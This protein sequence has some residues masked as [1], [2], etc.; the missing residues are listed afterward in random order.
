MPAV[1]VL[2]GY[3][4]PYDRITQCVQTADKVSFFTLCISVVYGRLRILSLDLE[5]ARNKLV[6]MKGY[7]RLRTIHHL[8]NHNEK[9]KFSLYFV[10]MDPRNQQRA[11]TTTGRKPNR[12]TGTH[13]VFIEENE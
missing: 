9:S 11:Y 4:D 2:W 6:M 10:L 8:K 5:L 3:R 7:L 12:R 1:D 13:R